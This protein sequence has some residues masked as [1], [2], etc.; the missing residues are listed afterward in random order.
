M[1][2]GNEYA[3][4]FAD[5]YARTPKAVYRQ[6]TWVLGSVLRKSSSRHFGPQ[7]C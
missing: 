1:K 6:L 3:E 5:L 4:L 2:T 7:K